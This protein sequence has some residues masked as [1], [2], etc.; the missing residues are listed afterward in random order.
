[1]HLADRNSV[2]RAERASGVVMRALVWG[3]L[4]LCVIAATLFDLGIIHF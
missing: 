3:G 1:M 4:A 2:Q